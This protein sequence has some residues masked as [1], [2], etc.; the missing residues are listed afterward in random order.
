MRSTIYAVFTGELLL[1]YA[2]E[3]FHACNVTAMI[4]TLFSPD[5]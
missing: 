2:L 3:D 4:S 1:G 5:S